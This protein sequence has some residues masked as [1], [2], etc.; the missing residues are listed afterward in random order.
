MTKPM[1]TQAIVRPPTPSMVE[2][3]SEAQMGRPNYERALVQHEAYVD[4]LRQ[5]G[6]AVTH[7]PAADE[8]PDACFVEDVALITPQCAILTRPGALT[9]RG[10][11]ALIEPV[12]RDRFSA[13]M[14]I[15][16]PGTLEAG[17]V[18]MVGE[19]YYIGLSERTNQAGADQLID[20]LVSVGLSGSVV[21]MS[22]LLHLKTGVS[23]LEQ[24]RMLVVGEFCQK[25]EFADYD[26]FELESSDAY[27]ANSVWINDTVLVPKGN[28]RT[29]AAIK[30]WGYRLIELDMSEFQKLD[31]GLS[32]L[33]LR[34]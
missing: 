15:T 1:F 20:A 31:G 21:T 27:S 3:L 6:L 22:E 14:T 8:F 32:C 5:C 23:Y 10:E 34:F 28:E 17:D 12:I 2:G 18:M 4:A 11:V 24:N 7:L 19:H 25:A 33:S 30:A 13:V 16:E 26:R 9:R 29:S